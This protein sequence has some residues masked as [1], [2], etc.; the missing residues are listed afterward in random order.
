[1]MKPVPETSNTGNNFPQNLTDGGVD[2]DAD[3]AWAPDGTKIAFTRDSN[4]WTVNVADPMQ[5]TQVTTL[6]GGSR[7]V[8]I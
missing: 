3:P 8:V 1:M 6:G 2:F 4:I 7:A 5:K